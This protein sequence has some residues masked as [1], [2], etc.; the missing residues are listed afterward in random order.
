MVRRKGFSLLELTVVLVV[1][2]VLSGTL[3]SLL[4][5]YQS[6]AE[7]D[8]VDINI[9]TLRTA[10]RFHVATLLLAGRQQELSGLVGSDP[11]A[12]LDGAL[13]GYLGAMDSPPDPG[14]RGCWYFD[15]GKR[16]L[17]YRTRSG[18]FR[19]GGGVRQ[20]R[21]VPAGGR[22]SGVVLVEQTADP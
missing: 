19:I 4:A 13:P 5:R 11:V 12:A 18:P 3:F 16:T 1:V 9:R 14:Q 22:D 15:R 2:L 8:M 7:Q 21:V 17:V 6:R 10:L 20:W